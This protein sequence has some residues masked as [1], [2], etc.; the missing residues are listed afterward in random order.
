MNRP[1]ALVAPTFLTIAAA[2]GDGGQ[3]PPPTDVLATA[4]SVSQIEVQWSPRQGDSVHRV[5]FGLDPSAL[6]DFIEADRGVTSIVVSNLTPATT[7]FFSVRSYQPVLGESLPSEVI[8]ATTIAG[9]LRPPTALRAET[10]A[11]TSVT[12]VWQSDDVTSTGFIIERRQDQS[13]FI[14]VLVVG[15]ND[16]SVTVGGLEVAT[17]YDFRVRAIRGAEISEASNVVP[18]TT[19]IP[20]GV[21][22]QSIYPQFGSAPG[23][24]PVILRGWGFTR[25]TPQVTFDDTPATNVIVVDD[26]H[27][28]CIAP[29]SPAGAVTVRVTAGE[30]VSEPS[31]TFT[32]TG[33][34]GP[35]LTIELQ[36]IPRITFDSTIGV[37]T[38]A[39]AFV[40]RDIDGFPVQAAELSTRTFVD[41]FELGVSERFNEAPLDETSEELEQNVALYLTLDAS[42]S[43][44]TQF[45]PEQFTPML[46]EAN[47][48]IDLGL[49]IWGNAVD[50]PLREDDKFGEFLW[51][52]AWFRELIEVPTGT[53][54][55][56]QILAIPPP[57]VGNET[58]MR[59]AISFQL[60]H[61]AQDALTGRATGDLDRHIVVVFTDGQDTLSWFGNAGVS[62]FAS[63]SDGTPT[64]RLGWR[65]TEQSDLLQEL[66]RHPLYPE[67]LSVYAVGLGQGVDPT[68]LQELAQ[69]GLGRFFFEETDLQA[70]FSML[71]AEITD[72][73][74]RGATIAV[75]PDVYEFKVEVERPQ[76]GETADLIFT[77]RG[78]DAQ[79]GFIG[80]Q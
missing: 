57:T 3:R 45:V 19:A 33:A 40:V 10:I 35:G 39:A 65:A 80:R 14:Q 46:T 36:G 24:F 77:F 44:V 68:P 53:I 41:G 31:P 15:P 73:L 27:L 71:S 76:T 2:C 66:V 1:I 34:N 70:V 37:T 79:A 54:T 26:S 16:R 25:G 75:R 11:P 50:D 47:N 32:Y 48:L 12:L 8:S 69:V 18:I 7:Y 28:S 5:Y 56:D 17:R 6:R 61:S 62:Q 55:P 29:A 51:D 4:L 67:R 23:G 60:N 52:V 43:L 78:G 21:G 49:S 20:P 30:D 38:V 63:L 13:P 9:P 58:K 74:T 72:Q 59:A 64:E 22:V 42:F